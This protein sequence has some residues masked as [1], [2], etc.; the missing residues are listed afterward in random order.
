MVQTPERSQEAI[1]ADV[2]RLAV[3]YYE[4]TGRPLGVT[5]EVAEFEAATKLKL[6]LAGTRT[7]GYDATRESEGRL[8]KVQVKGRRLAGAGSLY[9]GRVSKIDLTKPFDSVVLVLLNENYEAMEI[10]EAP[11]DK[12][13][14]RLS[15]PGSKSRND[16][17]SL[18]ISQFKSIAERVWAKESC[19]T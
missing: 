13:E 2:K 1:L 8:E 5:G 6:E 18:G 16:R 19:R 12:V 9:R 3:E 15:D 10:W 14:S 4:A 7:A 17:G 11:R